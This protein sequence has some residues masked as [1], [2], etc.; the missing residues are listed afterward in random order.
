MEDTEFRVDGCDAYGLPLRSDQRDGRKRSF[1]GAVGMAG[2][3]V[4]AVA[5][6]ALF[7]GGEDSRVHERTVVRS[8][9]LTVVGGDPECEALRLQNLAGPGGG[10]TLKQVWVLTPDRF[11]VLTSLDDELRTVSE[12]TGW[13]QWGKSLAGAGR[14]LVGGEPE[15]FGP[16]SPGEPLL[17]ERFGE[18]FEL[19]RSDVTGCQPVTGARGGQCAVTLA[20]GSGFLLKSRLPAESQMMAEAVQ[21]FLRSGRT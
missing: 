8:P 7:G 1:V 5:E 13:R 6:T 14:E 20:D 16:N 19:K 17:S 3:S 15:G 18:W 11:A 4:V 21:G 2:L 10:S 9:D 12:G